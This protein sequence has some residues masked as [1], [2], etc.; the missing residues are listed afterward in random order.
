MVGKAVVQRLVMKG[1]SVRVIGRQEEVSLEGVEYLSCDIVDFGRLREAVRGC[2][3]IVHLAALA[4]PSRG[5]LEEI[6]KVNCQGTFNVFQVAALEGIQRVVQASSINATGQFYGVKPAPIHYLPLDEDHPTFS[7]DVYSFSKNVIEEIGEFF[8][9]RDGITSLAFRLPYVAPAGAHDTIRERRAPIHDIVEEIAGFSQEALTSWFEQA[10]TDFNTFRAERPFE[11]P[12]FSSAFL[13]G[14]PEPRRK[15]LRLMLHRVNFF[16]MVDE[17][18]SAQAVEKGL[19][20]NF[21]GS[22][23]LFIND[24]MNWTEFET[25]TLVKFFYPDVPRLKKELHGFDTLVSIDKARSLI[26]FE[27]EYT[28][29]HSF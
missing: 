19:E 27:P 10:W 6:F 15:A 17:R 21:E 26:G 1:Y 23:A 9:R 7:T 11:K 3:A 4:N 18:D 20:A 22:H 5:T 14:L 29:H 24:S 8:W 2:N 28:F 13:E 12:V 16:T 25:S